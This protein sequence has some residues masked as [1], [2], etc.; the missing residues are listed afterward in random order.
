MAKS[1]L[2]TKNWWF[3]KSTTKTMAYCRNI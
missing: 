1:I 3:S 2:N